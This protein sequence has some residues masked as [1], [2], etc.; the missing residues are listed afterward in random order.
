MT[1]SA[2]TEAELARISELFNRVRYAK[3]MGIE[4]DEVSRGQVKM[5]LD[6]H[7][8]L[9]QVN[10]VLHGGSIA[11]LIDTAAAFAVITL[12]E[13]GQ[14]ATTTDLTIHFLRPVDSGRV[15]AI[16]RVL[17]SG[18]R[19]LVVTIEVFDSSQNLISTAVTTYIRIPPKPPAV[20]R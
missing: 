14:S 7:D 2:L 10:D 5:H 3:F 4:L 9:R 18:R 12:I 19:L 20:K 16:A 6:A 8:D 13:P 15:T 17:R 1:E 11:S